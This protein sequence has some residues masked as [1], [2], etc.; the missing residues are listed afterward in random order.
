[1][2]LENFY[3]KAKHPKREFLNETIIRLIKRI[4]RN[5]QKQEIL[6]TTSFAIDTSN[7]IDMKYW[8]CFKSLYF[9]H[10]DYFNIIADT[11]NS[12]F[13]DGKSKKIHRCIKG[14]E[15]T[16]NNKFC[17]NFFSNKLVQQA[18]MILI[19]FLFYGMNPC[20]L[21]ERFRFSC[22]TLDHHSEECYRS[23]YSLRD[24][25][26]TR[27]FSDLEVS[28]DPKLIQMSKPNLILDD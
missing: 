27:Y 22:C 26:N 3:T 23:W 5:V 10:P 24:Y 4:F 11:A 25:M 13:T 14:Q 20:K 19:E 7:K 2:I 9:K 16:F 12:P 28:Y 8:D 6:T 17:R 18:F 1:M 15:K 21:N